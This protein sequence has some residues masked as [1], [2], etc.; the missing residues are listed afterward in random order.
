[1]SCFD[2]RTRR[3]LRGLECACDHRCALSECMPTRSRAGPH[4]HRRHAQAAPVFINNGDEVV[5]ATHE[6]PNLVSIV[7]LK[8]ERRLAAATAPD[9]RQPSV[10]PGLLA[11]WALSRLWPIVDFSPDG[12][13]D[14]GHPGEKRR[15]FQP[16]ESRATA[17]NPSFAPDGSRVVFSLSDIGGHQIVSVNPQGKELKHLTNAAGMNAWPAYS[18]DGRKIAFGSSRSGDFEIY[19]MNADGSDVVRPHP[20]P[21]TGRSPRLVS[22]W[23]EDRVHQQSGRELRDLCHERRW[24]QPAQRDLAPR[25][26]RSSHV[27]PRRPAA[28]V[29]FR[30]RRR[31]GPLSR[32]GAEEPAIVGGERAR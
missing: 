12:A 29:C 6:V 14:P 8:L 13:R 15:V 25:S 26:R 7:C 21:G 31:L 22:R 4:D 11:R 32:A 9:G 1:M 18:P 5:F 20:E 27:A 3:N 28:A 17:R 24:F 19:A 23:H 2:R 16:R 10:R 30:S